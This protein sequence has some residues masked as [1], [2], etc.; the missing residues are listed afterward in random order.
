M[1]NSINFYETKLL[2][3]SNMSKYNNNL[4]V[5]YEIKGKKSE[6]ISSLYN[7]A[8]ESSPNNIIIRNDYGLYLTRK[9]E[10]KLAAKELNK[11][12]LVIEKQPLLHS[13]LTAIYAR[14]GQYNEGLYSSSSFLNTSSSFLF[15]LLI[16]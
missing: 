9:K 16:C 4:A 14:T 2:E 3:N 6:E 5:L 1:N 15:Y 13:N 8:L 7:K 12:L 10:Y 11:G